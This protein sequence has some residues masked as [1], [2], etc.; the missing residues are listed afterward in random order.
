[1]PSPSGPDFS[2]PVRAHFDLA[3]DE[4]FLAR[5]GGKLIAQAWPG[6]GVAITLRADSKQPDPG[7]VIGAH[8]LVAQRRIEHGRGFCADGRQ[9]VLFHVPA[10]AVRHAAIPAQQMIVGRGLLGGIEPGADLGDALAPDVGGR[11]SHD[12]LGD[13]ARRGHGLPDLFE[14]A[15]QRRG[16]DQPS[17]RRIVHAAVILVESAVDAWPPLLGLLVAHRV[18]RDDAMVGKSVSGSAGEYDARGKSQRQVSS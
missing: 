11:R 3:L 6:D 14:M 13:L 2:H 18:H 5:Q 10:D 12:A 15:S 17:L 16:F 7:I 4:L 9:P 8:R 1:M